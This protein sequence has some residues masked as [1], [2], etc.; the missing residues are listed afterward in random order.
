VAAAGFAA[1]GA[2]RIVNL[3][4]S[5][6][7]V[8]WGSGNF[9]ATGQPLYI[10]DPL[11]ITWSIFKIRSTSNGATRTITRHLRAPAQAADG[12]ISGAISGTGSS[13][14][15]ISTLVWFRTLACGKPYSQ[16]RK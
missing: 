2:D 12:K 8:T 10:G 13:N 1:Y 15:V 4:G 5:G 6:A 9:V 7:G 3:G 14:L 16:Q 11:P